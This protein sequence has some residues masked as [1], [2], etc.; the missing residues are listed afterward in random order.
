MKNSDMSKKFAFR[1]AVLLTVAL[2]LL[3][4][5]GCS[6]GNDTVVRPAPPPMT[7]ESINERSARERAEVEAAIAEEQATFSSE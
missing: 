2:P 7:P 6:D 5:V 4:V 3:V 1:Y